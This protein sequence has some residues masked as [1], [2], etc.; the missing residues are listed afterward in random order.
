MPESKRSVFVLM[1]FAE[2]FDDVYMVIK[3]AVRSASEETGVL[4]KCLRA[5]D[6]APTGRITDQVIQAIG[7]ADLLIAEISGNNPNVMYELGYGHALGKPAVILNQDINTSP[8]DL[9]DF[10]QIVYPRN[11]LTKE[12]R[13]A[14]LV[15]LTDFFSQQGEQQPS[16]PEPQQAS[17]TADSPLVDQ[18]PRAMRPSTHLTAELQKLHLRLQFARQQNDLRLVREIAAAV[19]A[20]LSQVTVVSGTDEEDM[21]N[22]AAPAGNC[23]IELEKAGLEQEAE[24]IYRKTIG[25]FPSY[26]GVRCQ[27]ADFLLDAGRMPEARQELDRARQLGAEE[28]RLRKIELKFALKHDP[29]SESLEEQL[30]TVFEADPGNRACVIPYLL[31]LDHFKSPADKFEEVC[32]AWR[33]AAPEPL[34]HEADRALADFLAKG[35]DLTAVRR[36]VALYEAL[37]SSVPLDP[38]DRHASLHNVATLYAQLGDRALSRARWIE[39]YKLKPN[40]P[41][42]RAAFSQ[43]L[44]NWGELD[45]ALTVSEARP[46]PDGV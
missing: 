40:D 26:P 43:R 29:P 1:P 18:P 14:L 7:A 6:I 20:L 38:D 39:A 8:F 15:T 4:L 5:D 17:G 9:K 2:D 25:I 11:R 3:D 21:H 44:A 19:L 34:K 24:A 33:A 27:Y 12:C 42:V 31:Y 46:L 16:S 37:L 23:G 35:E 22:S 30:R 36:A 32:L 13:A 10:R 41:T 45:L 28:Q